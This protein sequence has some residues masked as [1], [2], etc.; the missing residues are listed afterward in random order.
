MSTAMAWQKYGNDTVYVDELMKA[1]KELYAEARKYQGSFGSHFRRVSSSFFTPV[2]DAGT[3][4]GQLQAPD[5]PHHVV[6]ALLCTSI[7]I[8]PASASGSYLYMDQSQCHNLHRPGSQ[9]G[10]AEYQ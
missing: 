10:Y 7:I 8:L 3:I 1:A 2:K 9:H 5:Q 4:M 6:Q